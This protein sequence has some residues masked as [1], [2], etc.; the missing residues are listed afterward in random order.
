[1]RGDV[2]WFSMLRHLVAVEPRC[3]FGRR[4]VPE[5]EKRSRGVAN[6]HALLAA[7]GLHADGFPLAH[8]QQTR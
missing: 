5:K 7:D 4:R 2:P 1:M 6:I 3:R 8:P